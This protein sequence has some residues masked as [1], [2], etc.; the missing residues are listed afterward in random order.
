M[1]LKK[2]SKF[3]NLKKGI[4]PLFAL[5]FTP[6][7][8][9]NDALDAEEEAAIM[10]LSG[11]RSARSVAAEFFSMRDNKLLGKNGLINK[12]KDLQKKTLAW[13]N[14]WTQA[15]AAMSLSGDYSVSVV[16]AKLTE[17]FEEQEDNWRIISNDRAHLEVQIDSISLQ[18]K[19]MKKWIFGV[20][21]G[22]F[23]EN[24][25]VLK[26]SMNT[27]EESLKLQKTHLNEMFANLDSDVQTNKRLFVLKIKKLWIAAGL[28]NV[29]ESVNKINTLMTALN[30]LSPGLARIKAEDAEFTEH[31]LG[32]R[33]YHAE[34]S[35]KKSQQELDELKKLSTQLGSN[36]YASS[37]VARA[38]TII[39]AQKVGYTERLRGRAPSQILASLQKRIKRDLSRKCRDGVSNQV[40]CSTAEALSNIPAEV[41]KDYNAEQGLNFEKQWK[42]AQY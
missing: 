23:Q 25:N 37:I 20:D 39:A 2:Y 12:Q 17:I 40:Q 26:N 9:A 13:L 29:D 10:E 41:I 19:N 30:K 6:Q 22:E 21:V 1:F 42:N 18:L 7:S 33:I 8:F 15:I 28:E 4:I 24:L 31:L 35:F 3:N 36:P 14:K 27:L 11:I 34:D 32:H 38:E 16:E 5:I